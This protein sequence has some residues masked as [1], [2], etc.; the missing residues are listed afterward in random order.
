[1]KS[2]PWLFSSITAARSCL[3]PVETFASTGLTER[4]ALE[5]SISRFIVLQPQVTHERG[6]ARGERLSRERGAA[7]VDV[8]GLRIL[9]ITTEV[10]YISESIEQ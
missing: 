3:L 8:N 10:N 1:M 2:R 6:E 9:E 5:N 4:H 7:Q